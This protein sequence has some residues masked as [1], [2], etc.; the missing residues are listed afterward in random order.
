MKKVSDLL[1]DARVEKKLTLDE[2]ERETKIKKEFIES[3]EK[4][5]FHNLPSESYALGFV[6]NY[7]KFLGIA[8]NRAIPLFR[9]QYAS[10]HSLVIIP[11]FR[12]SQD[13]FN[14]KILNTKI[15]LVVGTIFL[16]A[17]YIFFQYSSLIFPPKLKITEP[18][19]GQKISGNVIEV[20]GKTDPYATVFIGEDEAY[21]NI[22][23]NF[24]KSVYM[25]SGD[26]KIEVVA[27]NRFGKESRKEINISVK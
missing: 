17:L 23:G 16:V 6:K 20:R 15:L 26:N 24:K 12:K 2:V 10:K 9:R 13:K 3:I 25:F 19:N 11:E 22:A 8:E 4:G 5:A 21:V 27:R 14:K 7:A 18:Q 1:K